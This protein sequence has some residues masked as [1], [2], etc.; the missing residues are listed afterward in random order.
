MMRG[1]YSC[2]ACARRVISTGS[3]MSDPHVP[4]TEIH[5]PI[6]H[7]LQRPGSGVVFLE[8][9]KNASRRER[10]TQPAAGLF[11]ERGRIIHLSAAPYYGV[12]ETAS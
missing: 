4:P 3:A 1:F 11:E 9:A 8:S 12:P 2:T 10:L 7:F 6:N 5:R